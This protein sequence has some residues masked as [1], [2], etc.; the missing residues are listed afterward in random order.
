MADETPSRISVSRD[1]LR[2]EL[3]EMELRLRVFFE[4]QL[5]GK[6]D[7]ADLIELKLAMSKFEQGE[8]TTAMHR[9]VDE[10]IEDFVGAKSTREWTSRDRFISVVQVFTASAAL[11]LS[12]G[13]A[14]HTFGVF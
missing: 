8:F 11:I 7:K 12:L 10:R 6:A 5:Q 2:A 3:A 14:A 9:T 13:L 1:T 4:A